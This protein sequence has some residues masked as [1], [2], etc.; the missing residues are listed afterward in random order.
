MPSSDAAWKLSWN[1]ILTSRTLNQETMRGTGAPCCASYMFSET[2]PQQHCMSGSRCQDSQH[3]LGSSHSAVPTRAKHF[4]K[5]A[6]LRGM[7]KSL[8]TTP[9]R[10]Q[11]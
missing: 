7:W 8:V 3:L 2:E 5:M 4:S 9:N 10:L 1:L 6:R 11:S